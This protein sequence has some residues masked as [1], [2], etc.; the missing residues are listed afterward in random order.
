MSISKVKT[1][2]IAALCLI[3]IF[4]VALIVI[5]NAADARSERLARTH[6]VAVLDEFGISVSSD[7]VIT[8]GALRTMRTTRNL[9]T[10]ARIAQATLGQAVMTPQGGG[11]Y[12]YESD[13]GIATFRVTGEFEISL[14][15]GVI[16]NSGGTVRAAEQLLRAMRLETSGI[17]YLYGRAGEETVVVATAYRGAS[18]FNGTIEFNFRD[19]S[20]ETISGRYFAEIEPAYDGT[21]ISPPGTALLDFLAAVR[22]GDAESTRIY[23]V[24]A[25]YFYRPGEG[26]LAPAWLIISY[27]GQRYIIDDA[28]GELLRVPRGDV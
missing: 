5:D 6:A 14:N 11:I 27:T 24:E 15:E 28:S 4:F 26:V 17:P 1:L 21:E 16:T 10:E 22:R 9:D 7:A 12:I 8:R 2:A 13:R 19:G 18:I 25:G 20:L 3:N 23:R